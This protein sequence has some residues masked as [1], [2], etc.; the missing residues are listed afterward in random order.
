MPQ[1]LPERMPANAEDGHLVKIPAI[2]INHAAGDQ[3]MNAVE[4][5]FKTTSTRMTLRLTSENGDTNCPDATQ[6]LPRDAKDEKLEKVEEIDTSTI[7]TI[8]EPTSGHRF[9]H[10]VV[11]SVRP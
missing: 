9:V 7:N 10:A 3:L 6:T 8:S 2:A 5:H 11:D 4:V 1:S